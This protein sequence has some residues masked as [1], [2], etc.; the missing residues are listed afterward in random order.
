[1]K[2]LTYLLLLIFAG[3]LL[4]WAGQWSVKKQSFQESNESPTASM[5]APT[6]KKGNDFPTAER[7]EY[8]FA[9]MGSSQQSLLTL[10][11]CACKIDVIAK[12][13]KYKDYLQAKTASL[14][15][16]L[17]GE[18]YTGFRNSAVVKE[19]VGKLK[20]AAIEADFNCPG[21]TVVGGQLKP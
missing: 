9:C 11:A 12:H 13:M 19:I 21:N 10:Y 4:F 17:P 14:M 7:A 8:V 6:S 18:R 16:Q 15:R 3:G 5:E 1:M 2:K 20:N